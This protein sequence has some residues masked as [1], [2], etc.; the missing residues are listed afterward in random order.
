MK[1]SIPELEGTISVLQNK[2][3]LL[4]VALDKLFGLDHRREIVPGP[5]GL[6]RAVQGAALDN[7]IPAFSSLPEAYETITGDLGLAHFGRVQQIYNA[8]TFPSML[9]DTLNRLLIKD[10]QTDYRWRDIV[11]QTTSPENFHPQERVR[12]KYVA[13]LPEVIE[14]D[15]YLE[16]VVNGDE[17]VSYSVGTRGATLTVTRRAFLNNDVQGIQRAVE[18][19][20]RS[21]WRTL[22]KACWAKI[23]DNHTYDVDGVALFHSDHA[24]LGST[25]LSVASLTAAREAIFAQKEPGGDDRLGLGGGALLLVVPIELEATAI[26]INQ[27][28]GSATEGNPFFHRFGVNN[29]RIFANPLITSDANDWYLFDISGAVGILELGFLLGHQMPTIIIANDGNKNPTFSQDRLVWK[30]RHEWAVD[31]L[32]YRGAYKAEVT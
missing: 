32:D 31:I 11:T 25:A 26:G 16:A 21:A 27:W 3:E 5:H 6:Q 10:Y 19:L 15:D 30:L 22:A 24:N 9:A 7:T 17:K 4:Q 29:E 20:G 1:P 28:P 14:D 2:N 12:A 8:P 13:D 18:Q 23:L